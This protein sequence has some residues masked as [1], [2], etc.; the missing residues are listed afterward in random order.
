MKGEIKKLMFF[1]AS[2]KTELTIEVDGVDEFETGEKVEITKGG[3][4]ELRDGTVFCRA[5]GTPLDI[6]G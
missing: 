2:N 3:L 6:T 4:T 1:P 5:C